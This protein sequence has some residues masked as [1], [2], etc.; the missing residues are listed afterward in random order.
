MCVCAKSGKLNVEPQGLPRQNCSWN[1]I[2][3]TGHN[4]AEINSS[5][6]KLE[7]ENLFSWQTNSQ[8][9][10]VGMSSVNSP[11]GS[12][13]R[14]SNQLEISDLEGESAAG[15]ALFPRRDS[16]LEKPNFC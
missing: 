13:F 3:P 10:E 14:I 9:R 11:C 2:S 4:Q 1:L 8:C 7:P 12:Y 5:T 16:W 6:T 15:F